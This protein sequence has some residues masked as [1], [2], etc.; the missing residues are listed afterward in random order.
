MASKIVVKELD[1]SGSYQELYP[2]VRGDMVTA[3][4][5]VPYSS[6]RTGASSITEACYRMI[7]SQPQNNIAPTDA[8][9]FSHWFNSGE[10]VTAYRV[11]FAT[12]SQKLQENYGYVNSSSINSQY[13]Y[14]LYTYS[15]SFSDSNTV[16]FETGIGSSYSM[17]TKLN[18]NHWICENIYPVGVTGTSNEYAINVVP[19]SL[20][21]TNYSS[22]TALNTTTAKYIVI[23]N[24]AVSV[25]LNTSNT[26]PLSKIYRV[27][28]LWQDTNTAYSYK[29][30]QSS[31]LR[32]I[33]TSGGDYGTKRFTYH[34]TAKSS[35]S[36]T[37][38]L[39]NSTAPTA[40]VFINRTQQYGT[41]KTIGQG[42]Y[43]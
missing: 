16:S 43:N 14:P 40:N 17:S 27:Y 41:A 39:I 3:R 28:K 2:K 11:S 34:T 33:I 7:M 5:V 23:W 4:G 15:F 6:G 18:T 42:I 37:Q 31:D 36:S 26:V 32:L 12:F 29:I 38:Y 20:I 30:Y 22:Q 35:I 21:S 1:S 25:T 24:T 10:T 19:L 8:I 13:I 9:A